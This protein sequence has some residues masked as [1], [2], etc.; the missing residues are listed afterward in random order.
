[1]GPDGAKKRKTMVGLVCGF[2]EMLDDI[3]VAAVDKG[4]QESFH[5]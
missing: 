5:E 2:R 4:W 3:G 1:M